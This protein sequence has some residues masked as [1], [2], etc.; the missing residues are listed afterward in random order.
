MNQL[1]E[2]KSKLRMMKTK[3]K[4]LRNDYE[5]LRQNIKANVE[6]KKVMRNDIAALTKEYQELKAKEENHA[7]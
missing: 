2:V 4:D 6:E 3:Y 7:Q 5:L 1:T